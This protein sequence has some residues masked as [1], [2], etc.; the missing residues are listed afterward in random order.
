MKLLETY[1]GHPIRRLVVALIISICIAETVIMLLMP[2]LGILPLW[3]ST[4]IDIVML[5]L[6][7]VPVIILTVAMPMQ[8][9]IHDAL[10]ASNEVST[11]EHQ[12]LAVL[13][14][15]AM[16]RDN[17][18]GHHI[19]RTQ[20]YVVLLAEQMKAM[21]H[22]V[23]KLTAG[24]IEMLRKVA[25]LHDIGKV[26]IPDAVLNKEG[27]L[28]A[29][30]RTLINTHAT[31]GE[32]I[33]SAAELGD[34]IEDLLSLAGKVAGGH[35]EKWDGT[36]YPRGIKGHRIPLEARIMALADVYD[37]LVSQRPYKR[38]WTHDQAVKEITRGRG[39]HFDPDVVDAFV[40]VA[41][42]FEKTAKQFAD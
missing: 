35:H 26:G 9:Y 1:P 27:K 33:L 40:A 8:K 30:E 41:D 15:L 3:G 39:T 22:H 36:G 17:E 23:G 38:H 24:Y 16:A 37:A 14:S 10:R 34:G 7:T 25:P 32:S 20:H 13:A 5:L 6:V 19:Q 28:T 11:R 4:A 2:Y 21:G 18:T 42:E 31:I 12:L 29:E